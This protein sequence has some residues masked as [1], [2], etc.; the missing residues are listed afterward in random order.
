V[1]KAAATAEALPAQEIVLDL[2]DAGF[3]AILAWL[4]PGAGHLYQR[5]T[6]KGLLLMVCILGTF[7]YGFYLGQGRVVYVGQ[8]EP[9]GQGVRGRV[10][11][12]VARLPYVSQFFAGL[13][14]LPAIV[15]ARTGGDPHQG[16]FHWSNWYVPPGEGEL[17]DLHKQ[18]HRFFELGK[19]FTM[20]AGLLNVLAI[21]DAWKG[22]AYGAARREPSPPGGT[23]ATA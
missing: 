23:P 2:K 18:L 5:R 11:K 8:E 16:L 14:A 20:V 15:R 1:S 6:A 17:N 19:V 22:P 4:W 10:A 21:Y 3:A 9:G 7:L 12:I 13:P